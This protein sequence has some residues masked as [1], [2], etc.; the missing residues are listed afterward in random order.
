[1][2]SKGKPNIRITVKDG[3]A[4]CPTPYRHELFVLDLK[5]AVPA[6]HRWWNRDTNAWHVSVRYLDTLTQLVR[7]N[8]YTE[9]EIEADDAE[10]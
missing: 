9:P 1:V 7:E 6:Y 3:W 10:E 8:Y 4:I 5:A 2:S